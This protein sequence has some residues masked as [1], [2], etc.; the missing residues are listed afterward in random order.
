LSKYLFGQPNKSLESQICILFQQTLR[1]ILSIN[2]WTLPV[3]LVPLSSSSPSLQS[4]FSSSRPAAASSLPR[5]TRRAPRRH[6]RLARG[7]APAWVQD[8]RRDAARPVHGGLQGPPQPLRP[9]Q[10]P[11]PGRL[12]GDPTRHG[13]PRP[14]PSR[15]CRRALPCRPALP[16][17]PRHG[18]SSPG[19]GDPAPA[20]GGLC[21]TILEMQ[22]ALTAI[23]RCRKLVVA[24]VHGGGVEV[25]A[26][27]AVLEKSRRRWRWNVYE[28]H[29]WLVI[30]SFL[31]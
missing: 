7:G 1:I 30:F 12:R 19:G 18:P 8:A 21:C 4:S 9:A 23:E 16:R 20:A 25:V 31:I 6:R 15:A 14:H 10:R 2:Q 11:Q 27:C 22:V 3:I 26:A 29:G 13:A 24:A 28:A 17:E 5:H